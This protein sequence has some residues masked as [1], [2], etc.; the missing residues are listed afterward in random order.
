ME[1]KKVTYKHLSIGQAIK[2]TEEVNRKSYFTAYVKAINPNFV[3]VEKWEKGGREEQLST[4]LMFYVEMT[5]REF[6]EKYRAEAKEVVKA[7][8]NKLHRDQ[9]GVHEMWNA[10]LYGDPYEIAKYCK[11]NSMKVIGHCTD[12]V[13]KT[14]IFSDDKLDVGVCAEFE[15]GDRIWCHYRLADIKNMVEDY[16]ELVS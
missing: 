11:D 5:Q 2:G 3:T 10:W 6:E 8:Q 9:I 4:S 15:D 1:Y 13:P 7:I 12:I 14:A 16:E